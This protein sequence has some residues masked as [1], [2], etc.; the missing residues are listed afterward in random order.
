MTDRLKRAAARDLEVAFA[1]ETQP[2]ETANGDF[3]AAWTR[4][5]TLA[6]R[7]AG[8]LEALSHGVLEGIPGVPDLAA[9]GVV[10]GHPLALTARIRRP[11]GLELRLAAP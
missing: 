10:A 8:A 5:G 9:G 7:R 1:K 4:S 3:G 11:A 6:A 2:A